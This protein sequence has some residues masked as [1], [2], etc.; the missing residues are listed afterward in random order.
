M[1]LKTFSKLIIVLLTSIFFCG[2]AI[3]DSSDAWFLEGEVESIRT[4]FDDNESYSIDYYN[5]DNMIIREEDYVPINES[6]WYITISEREYY[7]DNRIK[8]ISFNFNDV[9]KIETTFEYQSYKGNSERIHTEIENG[10]II[11]KKI[12][13]LNK[14]GNSIMTHDEDGV[15][16]FT[17]EYKYDKSNR[18][19]EIYDCKIG[20][21]NHTFKYLYD[22]AGKLIEK[23]I[24]NNLGYTDDYSYYYEENNLIK[25]LY[26]CNYKLVFVEDIGIVKE[27]KEKS[28]SMKEFITLYNYEF[29]AVGNWI[30]KIETKSSGDTSV[31][32]RTITYRSTKLPP[33][34]Q[35]LT[36]FHPRDRTIANHK[37]ITRN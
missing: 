28:D 24:I 29:D 12:N 23:K 34:T 14:Y 21:E 31:K 11:S 15:L 25:T 33:L 30:K 16:L 19:I 18:I 35:W 13:T 6:D 26:K 17:S 36:T 22:D 32:K 5:V 7:L 37:T 9:N 4:D 20:G 2:S 10:K 8:K 1:K 3:P 27:L